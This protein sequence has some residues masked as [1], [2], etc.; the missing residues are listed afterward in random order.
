[1]TAQT[2]S[3]Q[4]DIIWVA[5]DGSEAVERRARSR[6]DLILMDMVMPVMDGVEA[7]RRII[8][9]TPCGILIVTATVN[10]NSALVYEALGAGA[11]D[12]VKTPILA[13][14]DHANGAE[15]FLSKIEMI[16]KL[17]EEPL[18]AKRSGQRGASLLQQA[19]TSRLIAIGSSA[20]GPAAVAEILRVLPAHF[21][22]S[23]VVIQH[24]D[25]QFAEG[26]AEWLE[27]QSQLPVRLARDRDHP[28]PGVVLIAGRSD[29]LIFADST[30]LAYAPDPVDQAYRPSID[31]FFRSVVQHWRG[32]VIGV[33][34]TGMGQDGAAGL[35]ALRQA[36]Y[37]TIA[38][39]RGS[40]AV[41]GMPKAA[42]DMQAA[43]EILPLDL[44][45][46][47]LAKRIMGKEK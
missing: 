3:P 23:I 36:R 46:P 32:E 33:L 30:T 29:H 27:T 42:A 25:E 19:R 7:T 41:Y 4:H 8:S 37:H 31:V 40:S 44:I 9:H 18:I 20:G 47:T 11:I 26:L 24:V 13:S 17:I 15:A 16:G 6:P 2:P 34:L 45:G 43:V 1:V 39:D 12:A 21:R 28:E 35:K 22:A 10:T 38:Q 5:R 14:S